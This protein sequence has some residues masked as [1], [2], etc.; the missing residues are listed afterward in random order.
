MP[1]L[2]PFPRKRVRGVRRRLRELERDTRNAL[3]LNV[4]RLRSGAGCERFV[5]LLN[6]WFRDGRSPP[7]AVRS[8]VVESLLRV[9]D[10]WHPQLRELG[11]PFYLA[12]WLHEPIWESQ[13]VAAVGQT[14]ALYETR[15]H[16]AAGVPQ[17]PRT[18]YAQPALARFRW[19]AHEVLETARLSEL[20][21]LRSQH[22]LARA[23]ARQPLPDG[24]ELITYRAYTGWTGRLAG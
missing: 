4:E 3:R 19:T 13:V 11:Q 17:D 5:P 23:R 2:K 21:E 9:H 14:I 6:P 16:P 8:A 1:S 18:A 12:I 10:A 24:D 15:D 7:A 22:L 20:R